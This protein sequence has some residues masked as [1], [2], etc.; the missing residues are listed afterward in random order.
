MSVNTGEIQPV[1]G[2]Q[3]IASD[4]A[5][6]E[7][8]AIAPITRVEGSSSNKVGDDRP[9]GDASDSSVYDPNEVAEELQSFVNETMN[10]QLNFRVNDNG[11]TV[12][13]VL[14]RSTGELIRQIPPE[15]FAKV[16]EKLE[17]LRGVLF[18]GKV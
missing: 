4:L 14:D 15:K 5:K 10:I 11:K 13:Q 18:D 9:K 12:V 8:P 7:V 17:E 6:R 2:D 1:T 3:W 16:H